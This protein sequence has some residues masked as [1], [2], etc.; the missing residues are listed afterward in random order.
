M[1]SSNCPPAQ[2]CLTPAATGRALFPTKGAFAK[3]SCGSSGCEDMTKRYLGKKCRSTCPASMT[4]GGGS[5]QVHERLS[6]NQ[7]E[8]GG[9]WGDKFRFRLDAAKPPLEGLRRLELTSDMQLYFH[10]PCGDNDPTTLTNLKDDQVEQ[11]RNAC[12]PP[13]KVQNDSSIF[14]SRRRGDNISFLHTESSDWASR[15]SPS[16]QLATRSDTPGILGLCQ[17]PAVIRGFDL[18]LVFVP[19]IE[20]ED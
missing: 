17:E 3:V 7:K 11:E 15:C 12:E 8:A 14:E 10:P 6:A 2:A 1:P 13:P 5:G 4:V 19:D 9:R 18:P 16:F 20:I